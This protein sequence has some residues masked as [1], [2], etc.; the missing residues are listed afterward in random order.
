MSSLTG[1]SLADKPISLEKRWNVTTIVDQIFYFLTLILAIGVGF[2]L[3]WVA[4]EIVGLAFPAIQGYG[5]S[6]LTSTTWDPVRNIYGVLPQVYGTLVTSFIALL[7]AV[8][9][10]VGIA[11]FLSE[12]FVPVSIRTPIAFAI[13]LL[14]AVPSVV[15]GLWGIFV[16]IPFLRPFYLFLHNNFG[17]IPL[18][19]TP[20]RGN[21][22]LTLGIVLS[23]MIVPTI[24]AI[25][26]STLISL[27]R[28]L[29]QGALALGATRWEAI[30]RVLV[31]AGFSG[32]VGSIMLALGRALGETMAA[33]MLVGNANRIT[34]SLLAP[35]ATIASLIASQFGEA[36]R[37][38]VAALMYSGVVLMAMTLLVNIS[39]EV[40]IRR[41]QNIE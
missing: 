2:V 35:G 30:L 4:Y 13:E 10:G 36:G 16:F 3:T 9:F 38:Q 24:I 14:A 33:A 39:A 21:S 19:S 29:R 23:I 27:P 28:D 26:R 6:F 12:D 8:P 15:Y 32:I 22:L 37:A 25:S 40:I 31:P 17:W 20:P 5:L 41:F 18:F 7:I 34:A 11:I 1:D